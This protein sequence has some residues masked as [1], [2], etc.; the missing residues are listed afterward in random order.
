M[1]EERA[2]PDWVF[3][4]KRP[5]RD[6]QYF[7]NLTRC[8]FQGG[9]NWTMLANKWPNFKAAFDDFDIDKVAGYGLEEQERLL[10]DAGIIIAYVMMCLPQVTDPGDLTVYNVIAYTEGEEMFPEGYDSAQAIKEFLKLLYTK[11]VIGV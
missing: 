4:D 11:I 7:E 5:T 6:K 1:H 10:N 8:V 2:L 3:K 9:L